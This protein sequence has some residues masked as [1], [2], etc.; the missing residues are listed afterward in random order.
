LEGGLFTKTNGLGV[1]FRNSSWTDFN[2]FTAT[3]NRNLDPVRVLNDKYVFY[4]KDPS[5]ST[6]P[7]GVRNYVAIQAY[8]DPQDLQTGNDRGFSR[9]VAIT[10]RVTNTST[11]T[12]K[13]YRA[14]ARQRSIWDFAYYT[15]NNVPTGRNNENPGANGEDCRVVV[16]SA[17]QM[18][19][20]YS[21]QTVIAEED[22]IVGDAYIGN[23]AYTRAQRYSDDNA[24]K[25]GRFFVRGAPRLTGQVQFRDPR[26]FSGE[27]GGATDGYNQTA[28]G[29]SIAAA[30]NPLTRLTFKSNARAILPPPTETFVSA[31]SASYRANA[32]L[33]LLQPAN[34]NITIDSVATPVRSAWRIVLRNDLYTAT[35]NHPKSKVASAIKTSIKD[36]A[37]PCLGTASCTT[38]SGTMLIYKIP[39]NLVTPPSTTNGWAMEDNLKRAAFWGDNMRERDSKM[40]LT[41]GWGGQSTANTRMT[42][43]G[44]SACGTGSQRCDDYRNGSVSGLWRTRTNTGAGGPYGQAVDPDDITGNFDYMVVPSRSATFSGIIFV[45]GDLII[46]GVMKGQ[47]TFVATGDIYL[48]HEIQ[49]ETHPDVVPDMN[50]YINP[51][52]PD[53]IALIA[54][55]NIVIPNSPPYTNPAVNS[56]LMRT[57]WKDDWSDAD[58]SLHDKFFP[59]AGMWDHLTNPGAPGLV[60]P[61]YSDDGNEEIHGVYMTM[62]QSCS[63]TAYGRSAAVTCYEPENGSYT[64]AARRKFADNY[65]E[66]TNPIE[67]R[68]VKQFRTGLYAQARTLSCT[69]VA[70]TP[71]TVTCDGA[72]PARV[73]ASAYPPPRVVSGS[74]S[75]SSFDR[76]QG[77]NDSG[78]LRIIGAVIQ[79]TP[80]RTAYDFRST[81]LSAPSGTWN[82]NCIAGHDEPASSRYCNRIGFSGVTYQY[83]NRLK[84]MIPPCP[85]QLGMGAQP[86]YVLP[87]GYAGWEIVSW[88]EVAP[89]EAVNNAVW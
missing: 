9:P 72:F 39:F 62:G 2:A 82:A 15:L 71:P 45:E 51:I 69:V 59:G 46:S 17:E 77:G 47:L 1:P 48:D 13:Q 81:L 22:Q 4:L 86:Q 27:A 80:G 16:G 37:G 78:K 42:S 66:T 18:P 36:Q 33:Y 43:A 53:M 84:Q 8:L 73:D 31:D 65:S 54:M 85:G 40:L 26:A 3:G 34:V 70:G 68:D 23:M 83:D 75:Y 87:I 52:E 41:A 67:L 74:L 38:D 79:N 58:N 89:G 50:S 76:T 56:N 61:L 7:I 30:S 12:F 10:A 35:G 32:D 49:Y 28:G 60:E 6:Q 44:I 88:E 11:G 25:I 20:W 21:C 19:G 64:D 24:A 5:S 55:G 29:R 63:Q 14:Y 57:Y